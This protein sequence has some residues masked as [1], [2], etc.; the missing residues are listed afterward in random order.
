MLLL[1]TCLA[2]TFFC[3]WGILAVLLHFIRPDNW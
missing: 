1:F 2:C 3:C